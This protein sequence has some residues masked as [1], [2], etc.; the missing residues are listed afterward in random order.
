[1]H[2]VCSVLGWDDLGDTRTDE[3]RVGRV[4]PIWA[5]MSTGWSG[6]QMIWH[7]RDGWHSHTGSSDEGENRVIDF[8][9]RYLGCAYIA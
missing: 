8:D 3:F 4:R 2:Q 5:K 6:C 9:H 7:H 1:V